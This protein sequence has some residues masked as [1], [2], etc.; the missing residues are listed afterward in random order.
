MVNRAQDADEFSEENATTNYK[1]LGLK[2]ALSSD[3]V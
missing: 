3:L 2:T 1:G